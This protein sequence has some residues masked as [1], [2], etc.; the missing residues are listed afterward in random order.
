MYNKMGYNHFVVILKSVCM[1]VVR[2]ICNK[3][4]F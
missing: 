4:G 1:A 3:Y 2:T